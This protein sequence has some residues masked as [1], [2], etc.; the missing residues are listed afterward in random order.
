MFGPI[1]FEVVTL[2]LIGKTGD[3]TEVH[4]AEGFKRDSRANFYLIGEWKFLI[5]RF[6]NDG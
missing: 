4:I 5:S 6:F 3:P 2:G 1:I